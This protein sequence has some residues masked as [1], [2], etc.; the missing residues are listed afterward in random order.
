MDIAIEKEGRFE[1]SGTDHSEIVGSNLSQR[2][3]SSRVRRLP[4]L[5]L[6]GQ[7]CKARFTLLAQDGGETGDGDSVSAHIPLHILKHFSLCSHPDG[8]GGGLRSVNIRLEFEV[9][10][11]T[12]DERSILSSPASSKSRCGGAKNAAKIERDSFLREENSC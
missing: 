7:Q 6:T 1:V 5:L 2:C 10:A 12:E 8:K 4:P 9:S 3:L 11:D